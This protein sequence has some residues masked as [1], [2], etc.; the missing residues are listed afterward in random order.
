M[1]YCD[2]SFANSFFAP[3][4][5]PSNMVLRQ[6]CQSSSVEGNAVWMRDCGAALD[7]DICSKWASASGEHEWLVIDLGT[8]HQ[9]FNLSIFWDVTSYATD[10]LLET[11]LDQTFETS[12]QIPL[13]IDEG[14][15]ERNIVFQTVAAPFSAD[16]TFAQHAR[17]VCH[18]VC[19]CVC[20]CVHMC[21]YIYAYMCMHMYM[22]M[23]ICV[24]A[25]KHTHTHTHTHT[26]FVSGDDMTSGSF[27]TSISL[28]VFL[29]A[30]PVLSG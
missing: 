30:T 9:L 16:P 28:L 1:D 24:H 12:S 19:V 22:Y 23:Y 14:L 11:S 25:R 3:S 7:G 27:K 6:K 5:N 26:Q 17:G 20:L 13:G 18:S 21:I 2:P 4:Q 8:P 15:D 10:Y 29:G